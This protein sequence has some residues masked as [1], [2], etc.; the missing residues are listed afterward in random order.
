MPDRDSCGSG[1]RVAAFLPTGAARAVIDAISI[2][3]SEMAVIIMGLLVLRMFM[4]FSF[5]PFFYNNLMLCGA[6]NSGYDHILS[7][8]W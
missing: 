4:F 2:T 5:S 3:A 1:P 8:L 6:I 7:V